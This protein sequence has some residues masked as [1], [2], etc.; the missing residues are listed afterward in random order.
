MELRNASVDALLDGLMSLRTADE[1]Y[2]FLQDL[3]TIKELQDMAQ[4]YEAAR[5]L[6]E[7]ASYQ[8]IVE[9]IGISTT[10][11]G[12]VNRCLHYGSGGY[13]L[14]LDRMREKGGKE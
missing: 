14:V 11:I 7:G 12:R 6:D 5:L 3:C 9:R 1:C 10:T 13:R 2:A 4:R 8:K